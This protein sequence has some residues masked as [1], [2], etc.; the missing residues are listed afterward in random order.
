MAGSPS[1]PFTASAPGDI[2]EAGRL[3]ALRRY[4]VLDTPPE[5]AFD[6]VVRLAAQLLRAPIAMVSLTDEDRQ[7]FKACIGTDL[8]EADRSVSFCPHTVALGEVLV[9]PDASRDPRFAENPLVTGP[10]HLRFYAGAPLLT[11]DGYALGTLCVMDTLPRPPLTPEECG[12]LCDLA[13]GVVSELELRRALNERRRS[14]QLREAVL[15][16]ALDAVITMN[17]RG[18]I[19][20]WNPAA[21]RLFGY[22]RDE[23]L[24][25]DLSDLIIPE[26]LRTGHRQGLARYL[27]TGEGPVLGQRLEVPA[28]RRSGE[29]FPCELAITP[30]RL[31][32]DRLFTAYLRDLTAQ[33]AAQEALI[34]SHNLLQAVV[35]GVPE[36]IFVKDTAGRYV[37]INAAGA[38]RIGRP[39][40]E[41][42]GQ[43]DAALFPAMTAQ[44]SLR[45][46]THVLTT[47][48]TLSYEVT[49]LLPDGSHRTFLSAKSV[50]RDSQG[51]IQG[52][53]GAVLDITDRKAAEATIREQNAA[54][55]ALVR[56]RT[57]EV[58]EAQLE[59]L[60]RLARA[61]ELRDDN[62]GEHVQR[63]ATTAAGLARRLGL[64]EDEVTL[65]E[66]AAPLHDV[67]KIGVPDAVLLKPGRLTAEEFRVVQAHTELGA[68]LLAKGASRLV[69]A[70]QEI[71]L[72]HHERWDGQ[73]YPRGL[74]GEAIPLSGRIVAVADVLDALTSERPYKRAWTLAEALQEIRAQ[75]GAQFDP[76]VVAALEDLLQDAA[77]S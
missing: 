7:W 75:A 24:G 33:K 67:G 56:Q 73:G 53:I 34:T 41:I 3:Q 1:S 54:L 27:R 49:D 68:S 19:E 48:E 42:L 76:R 38:A 8:R 59:V 4:A 18:L 61:G 31:E 11:P 9:V 71:A 46:D 29:E 28:R 51:Q 20:E 16:S 70:A 25:R 62:T 10:H 64:A 63:V 32:G 43:D 74:A 23:V 17:V 5:A 69:R 50:Y 22:T 57:Q 12:I 52:L 44:T 40:Q 6:R 66:R 14:E 2:R 55:E 13:A 58:E 45:R 39:V 15:T 36:S 35:D 26:R 60:A 21:E 30:F 77:A 37:M 65:I 47:G 72:T